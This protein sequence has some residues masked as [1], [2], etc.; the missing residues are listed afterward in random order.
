M[1]G[2]RT[3]RE[4][5]GGTTDRNRVYGA[6]SLPPV[7]HHLSADGYLQLEPKVSLTAAAAAAAARFI[8]VRI[9][10]V[11]LSVRLCRRQ[12]T[13]IM[14]SW[15]RR[16]MTVLRR[17]PGTTDDDHLRRRRF[18]RPCDRNGYLHVRVYIMNI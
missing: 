12:V 14:L 10:I 1:Q 6:P 2:A 5:G 17:C 4:G 8:S 7:S 13:I 3:T 16:R 18:P 15:T 11:L 9:T